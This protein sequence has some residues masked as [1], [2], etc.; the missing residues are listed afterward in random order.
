MVLVTCS[1]LCSL[2]AA[3]VAVCEDVGFMPHDILVTRSLES[4]HNYTDI[5][6]FQRYFTYQLDNGRN[7]S[8][9]KLVQRFEPAKAAWR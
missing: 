3:D 5:H 8:A 2:V 7:Q 6:T 9:G 4:A 1:L